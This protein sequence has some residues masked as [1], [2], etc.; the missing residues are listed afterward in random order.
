[1]A[2][3]RGG[4]EFIHCPRKKKRKVDAYGVDKPALPFS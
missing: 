1:M 4:R 3:E 2:E